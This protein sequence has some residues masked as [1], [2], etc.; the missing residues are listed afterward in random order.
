[1]ELFS[2][3]YLDILHIFIYL[4]LGHFAFVK[5]LTPLLFIPHFPSIKLYLL[6]SINSRSY[7]ET[8]VKI[9]TPELPTLFQS[10]IDFDV[11]KYNFLSCLVNKTSVI[12][13]KPHEVNWL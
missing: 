4:M 6:R 7:N 12:F 11:P 1:M 2:K 5:C 13:K 8:F 9:F 3:N 10:K